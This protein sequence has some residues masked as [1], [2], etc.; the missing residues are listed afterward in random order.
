LPFEGTGSFA[1]GLIKFDGDVRHGMPWNGRGS[2]SDERGLVWTGTWRDGKGGGRIR[3]LPASLLEG[4]VSTFEG[5]WLGGLG[6]PYSGHGVYVDAQVRAGTPSSC[7]SGSAG[8]C[9]HYGRV[10]AQPVDHGKS[11]MIEMD[12][13]R[14]AEGEWREVRRAPVAR[15]LQ[16]GSLDVVP[17]VAYES[18]WS[19]GLMQTSTSVQGELYTGTG[20][21]RSPTTDILFDGEWEMGSGSG[22]YMRPGSNHAVP[23]RWQGGAI[24]QNQHAQQHAVQR[25]T[26]GPKAA[27]AV[28]VEVGQAALKA[29]AALM[30]RRRRLS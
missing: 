2:W 25:Q 24:I 6:P 14:E 26:S 1:D 3:H 28:A 5:T 13:S 4:E 11:A 17:S 27:A 12:L 30:P 9:R 7:S 16:S 18:A 8:A 20:V 10:V 19:I 15:A 21:W 23:G 29:T 22:T